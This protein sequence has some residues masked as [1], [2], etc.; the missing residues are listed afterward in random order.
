LKSAEDNPIHGGEMLDAI[1]NELV[2]LHR[3]Q[4]GRGPADTKT[5]ELDGMVVCVMRDV[6]LPAEKTLIAAGRLELVRETRQRHQDA[7][8]SE[9]EAPVARI[10]GRAVL[11]SVTA[12]HADPDMAIEV[13]ILGPEPGTAEPLA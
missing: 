13:F 4:F 12:V 8:R 9:V 5:F 2:A 10:T 3:R 1:S 11:G 6:F 7:V